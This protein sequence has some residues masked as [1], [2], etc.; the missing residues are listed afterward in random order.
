MAVE[1]DQIIKRQD[2][3][4]R[5]VGDVFV[6]FLVL[7]SRIAIDRNYESFNRLMIPQLIT[8]IT[9]PITNDVC[10][11]NIQQTRMV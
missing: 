2:T 5:D 10:S 3:H 7:A 8:F 11:Y 4:R 1:E 9:Q 6:F